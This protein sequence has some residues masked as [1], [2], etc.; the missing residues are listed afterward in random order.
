MNDADLKVHALSYACQLVQ[1]GLITPNQVVEYA[2][3]FY[4][5]LSSV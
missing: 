1:H 3:K 2:E 4:E 5:F